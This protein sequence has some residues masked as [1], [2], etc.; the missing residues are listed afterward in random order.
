[1]KNG[2]VI[3]DQDFQKPGIRVA[4]AEV[5]LQL[6]VVADLEYKVDV[7]RVLEVAIQL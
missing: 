4:V 1:M 6:S 5:A 3:T 7:V 2:S